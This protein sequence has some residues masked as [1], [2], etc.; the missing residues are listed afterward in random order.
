MLN[1]WHNLLRPIYA[2][3]PMA[4]ITDSPFRR[5]CK[6]FGAAVLYSEMASV[7]ALTHRP[8]KTLELL[9]ATEEESPY[10]VQLFGVE[11]KQFA[12]AVKL[13]TNQTDFQLST[14]NFQ[15]RSLCI[16]R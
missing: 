8:E 3:A 2:L 9:R 16:L 15:L 14:F 7:A 5:I 1:F 12:D 6:R 10:I 11:P 13:L 4:G